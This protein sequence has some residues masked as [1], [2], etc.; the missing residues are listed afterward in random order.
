MTHRR[1]ENES[2]EA[3]NITTEA[4]DKERVGMWR[5]KKFGSSD[6]KDLELLSCRCSR[7]G[8]RNRE[9]P[10]LL[11]RRDCVRMEM[12]GCGVRR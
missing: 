8:W 12:A 10:R 2:S 5:Q 6:A 4:C 7:I 11:Q 9:I 1:Y 3:K